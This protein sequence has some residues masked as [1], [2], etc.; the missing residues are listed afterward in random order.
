MTTR[1]TR[2]TFIAAS[3]GAGGSL[4]LSCR[5]D[6]PRGI[7]S[8]TTDTATVLNALVEISGNGTVRIYAPVPEIGQGV[9]TALPM[10]VAEELDCDW[11]SVVVVQ[12]PAG[13]RF[14]PRQRAAGS[15]SVRAYWQPPRMAGATARTMLIMAA[16]QR[17][18]C[19]PSECRTERGAIIHE[20]TNRRLGYGAVASAAATILAP[21]AIRLKTPG[22]FRLMGTPVRNVDSAAIVGGEI[23]YG[24][25]VRRPEML[26][27]VVA[28]APVYGG[29]LRSF[30]DAAAR[31][32]K[33]VRAVQ[34]M[35]S[36]GVPGRPYIAEGVAVLA[37][38]TWAALQ[39][40]D[41]LQIEWDP[42]PNAAESNDRLHALCE[43][44][45]ASP[46]EVI[47]DEGDVEA[48][49]RR[50]A[51]KLDVT[52][53]LPFLAHVCMEP[54]S[55][56]AEVSD[57][58]CELWAPTQFPLVLRNSIADSLKI[59]PESVTVNVTHIGGGFGR[60]LSPDFVMEAVQLARAAGKPVQLVWTRDDDIR[61]DFYRPFSYHRLIGGV[62]EHGNVSAWLHRQAGTSR[63]AFRTGEPAHASEFSINNFPA[64]L[65][66]NL[67]LEY[68]L[69]RS[70][71]PRALIRAP[72]ENAL[73]F[74]IQSFIDELAAASKS[75]PLDFRLRLLREDR[76]LPFDEDDPVISTLHMMRVLQLAAD[77]S[78]WRSSLG[79]N[80]GRGIASHFMAGTYVAWVAEVSVNPESGALKLDRFVG[81]IDCG[82]VVNPLG[83]AAQME[84]AVMD[85]AG[86]AL[87]QQ[88]IFKAGRVEQ[89]NFA[90]YPLLR[91]N[92]APEVEVH[93]VESQDA[94]TGVGEPPYPPVFPALTN[95]IYSATGKRIR[96]LP[97]GEQ[98]SRR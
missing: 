1:T 93:I 53:K 2:R 10:L 25:D 31:R 73:A 12:A 17:W 86:A 97:V 83:V 39:G 50:S 32:V 9:R 42:G 98:L 20:A 22:N 24:W 77:R 82:A 91:L 57:G 80:R 74:A 58:H 81:A 63:Y 96:Q 49:L 38:S 59:P 37:E 71:L 47:R 29:R 87:Y 13:E 70:N 28:R 45:I 89:G 72:G 23:V 94:P 44:L 48:A 8:T 7:R 95:A 18:E 85:A 75:D 56:V 66:P 61:H 62:D 54:L 78:E 92:E 43:K 90:D 76:D 60:R 40:R 68:A 15:R 26:R 3:L 84:G 52:Y 19:D 79:L 30:D 64:G 51:A 35:A 65:I 69:A 34:Q 36:A 27:A 33:G 4:L 21:E 14:G 5:V 55:C 16:A 46:A 6:P 11:A 41:A 67:R 88:I